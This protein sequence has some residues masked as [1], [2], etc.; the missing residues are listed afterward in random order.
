MPLPS[1]PGGGKCPVVIILHGSSG[2]EGDRAVRYKRFAEEL[3]QEGIIAIN[4]HYFDVEKK[5]R[6]QAITKVVSYAR[7]IVNA[8]KRKLGLVGYSLGGTIA[9]SVASRDSR[10][11]LLALSSCVLPEGFSR[12]DSWILP[13]TFMV[14][15]TEE[16]AFDTYEKLSG[17]L[18][19]ADKPF[20]SKI[21]EGIGRDDI[22]VDMF[23]ENWSGI[24]KF[25]VKNFQL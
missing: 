21:N 15:G 20:E 22:P 24:V 7:N 17:W 13:T 5:F 2:I 10:V 12:E 25:C 16:D 4:A 6:I 3:Q 9:M 11:K 8:D 19:E 18:R 23:W 14:A 1:N